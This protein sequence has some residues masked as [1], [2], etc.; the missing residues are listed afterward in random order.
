[1]CTGCDHCRGWTGLTVK[2]FFY[3]T[4]LDWTPKEVFGEI[5]LCRACRKNADKEKS[6]PGRAEKQRRE[7]KFASFIDTDMK[8]W[9]YEF[10]APGKKLVIIWED[11]EKRLHTASTPY[12]SGL[13]KLCSGA[14]SE[15]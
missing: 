9:P 12:L 1:M 10:I 15:R 4:C 11:A 5:P 6:G 13:I 8:N 2:G 3:E 7:P 14:T